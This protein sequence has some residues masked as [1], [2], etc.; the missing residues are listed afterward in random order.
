MHHEILEPRRN[1]LRSNIML[2]SC[3]STFYSVGCGYSDRGGFTIDARKFVN[4]AGLP[5]IY[6]RFTLQKQIRDF[7]QPSS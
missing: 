7:R 6:G 5:S 3:L 2:Y 4:H 1:E